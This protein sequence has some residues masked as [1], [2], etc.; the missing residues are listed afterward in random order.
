MS[1]ILHRKQRKFY[2]Q[3]Y[4]GKFL[5]ELLCPNNTFLTR[6]LA[7]DAP[8]LQRPSAEIFVGIE[9]ACEEKNCFPRKDFE[10]SVLKMPSRR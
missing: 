1:Q 4:V 8:I 3:K 5:S 7:K 2:S 10:K 9:K 6:E